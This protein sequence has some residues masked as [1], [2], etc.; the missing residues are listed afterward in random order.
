MDGLQ[1]GGRLMDDLRRN[2][3]PGRK[4]IRQP[5]LLI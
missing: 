4:K 5:V 3:A 2:A 1:M